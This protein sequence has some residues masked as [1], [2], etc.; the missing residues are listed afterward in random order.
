LLVVRLEEL[1][2]LD[3]DAQFDRLSTFLGIDRRDE[4]R[5]HFDQQMTPEHAHIDRWRTQTDP[6]QAAK[7]DADYRRVYDD[8]ASDGVTCLPVHPD[9]TARLAQTNATAGVDTDRATV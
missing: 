9:A 4:L 3:R 7:I 5:S 6:D 1:I 2:H 8:L